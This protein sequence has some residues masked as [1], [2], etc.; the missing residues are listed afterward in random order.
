MDLH[1]DLANA[2]GRSLR[3]RLEHALREAVRGGRL[4]PGTRLP[5]TRTLCAELGVSRGVVAD[6]YAQLAAEGYLRTRRGAGTTVAATGARKRAPRAAATPTPAVRHD[7]SPFRPAL[8]GFP[9]AAWSAATA[10]VL[11]SVPDE[12]LAYP[13]PAGTPEL[14]ETLAAYLGRVRGVRADP[15]QIVVTNGLRHGVDL[16]WWTLAARGARWLAVED[17]GWS[18]LRD[19]ASAA[20]LRVVPVPVDHAVW[21][22]S[23]WRSTRTSM[24]SPSPLRI[25]TRPGPSSPR[26][27]A[28]R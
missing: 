16:L 8:S 15:E 13:D 26:P 19:T 27:D 21:W 1:L 6:T 18:G 14:R 2:P 17:P 12:R 28:P 4:A 3:A 10:R 24:P 22:S 23:A 11:R 7:M 5:S 20:G 9:R 25:S